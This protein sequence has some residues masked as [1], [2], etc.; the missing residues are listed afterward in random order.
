MSVLALTMSVRTPS[1]AMNETLARST[2]RDV[3]LLRQSAEARIG[4]LRAG[5]VEAAVEDDVGHAAIGFNYVDVHPCT[6]RRMVVEATHAS[7]R[8]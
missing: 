7:R 2:T 5:N 3:L 1:D 4:L 6:I 8:A